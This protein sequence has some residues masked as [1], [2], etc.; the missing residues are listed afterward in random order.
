MSVNYSG[1][2][3]TPR[4]DLGRAMLE[5]IFEESAFVGTQ[6]LPIFK[7]PRKAATFAK[8]TAES[9]LTPGDVKRAPRS[10][11]NRGEI[12]AEDQSFE[13]VERGFEHPLDRS[14]R[15]LY[16]NDFDAELQASR[17]A[18]WKVLYDQEQDIANAVLNTTTFTTGN[19]K[20]TDVSTAWSTASAD[21]AGDV[22][23]AVETI[24]QRTGVMGDRMRLVVGA[25][26]L[27][28]LLGNTGLKGLIGNS[29]DKT[30]AEILNKAGA[31]MGLGGI[32]VGKGVY[33]SAKA[34]QSASIT[35]I[36]GSGW[37]SVVVVP[38]NAQDLSEPCLGRTML[39]TAD[40]PEAVMIEEY[41]EPQTRSDI[42][43]A[44]V[45]ADELIIDSSFAQLL[46]IAG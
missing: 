10:A 7:T 39:W 14:E 25:G 24:R 2:Y 36:W 9:L 4:L 12:E 37:A 44:R 5:Y 45:H 15:A 31:L 38:N 27:P 29:T 42:Y 16:A 18:M 20:R 26:V 35:D 22:H 19:G 8:I 17:A 1:S 11:Y 23:D 28:F 43:R 3:G 6:V 13:C 34:G 41:A 30:V 21:I 40:T 33:N 32:L 46:D